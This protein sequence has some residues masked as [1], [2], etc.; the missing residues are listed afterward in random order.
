MQW[1]D[2]PC[3]PSDTLDWKEPLEQARLA[4][5]KG[6]RIAWRCLLGMEAP[7]YP[8]GCEMQFQS[9][10]LAMVQFSESVWPEFKESTDYICLYRGS[11]H[12]HSFFAWTERQR[13][14]QVRFGEEE[15]LFC[16]DAYAIY[17]RMLMSRLPD[18]AKILLL[19]DLLRIATVSEALQI[20]S[21]DRFEH[22]SIGLRGIDIP[23]EGLWW[24]GD[25]LETRTIATKEA[26]VF[27]EEFSD[28]AEELCQIP[29]VKILF[30]QT[31][32][33]E[34]EGIDRI[35]A[36]KGS[37]TVQGARKLSGFQA[38]GG[39]VIEI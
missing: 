36:L 17:F 20:I 32:S 2:L 19:F 15:P 12:F 13:D 1:I 24:E 4:V 31:I 11:A 37:L 25:H 27:P 28:R 7:Y 21:K 33:E 9:A 8:L 18:E 39:E 3:K 10:S 23:L 34:W 26:V 29:G 16:A 14:D 5:A 30:E 35:Y 22:F 38:A 6:E